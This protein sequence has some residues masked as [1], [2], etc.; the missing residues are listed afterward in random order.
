MPSRGPRLPRAKLWGDL[1]PDISGHHHCGAT[2]MSLAVN[3]MQGPE[4]PAKE[5]L[6]TGRGQPGQPR[7]RALR[8]Q[9]L[10]DGNPVPPV[11]RAR[12]SS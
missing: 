10:T 4:N 8:A 2:V 7:G 3:K 12:G 1:L 9:F 6:R 5:G 11:P